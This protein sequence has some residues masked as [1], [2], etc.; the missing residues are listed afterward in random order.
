VH[1]T[2]LGYGGGGR[3]YIPAM[4]PLGVKWDDDHDR[5]MR[6]LD[7]YEFGVELALPGKHRRAVGTSARVPASFRLAP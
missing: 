6:H 5:P 4:V 2:S 7:R 1:H 3:K